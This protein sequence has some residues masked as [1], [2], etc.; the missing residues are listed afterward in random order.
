M[1]MTVPRAQTAQVE[2][3]AALAAVALRPV[4]MLNTVDTARMTG[5]TE[6]PAEGEAEGA[7]AATV[8]PATG[9]AVGMMA[10]AVVLAA[11]APAGP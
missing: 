6:V 8:A 9:A 5:G 1:D 4:P 7:E 11:V 10:A 2:L 3:S